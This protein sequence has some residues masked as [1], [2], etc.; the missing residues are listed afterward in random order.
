MRE[1]KI[2]KEKL[3]LSLECKEKKKNELRLVSFE[4]RMF[5]LVN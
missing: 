1:L 3:R 2:V 5:N 4:V